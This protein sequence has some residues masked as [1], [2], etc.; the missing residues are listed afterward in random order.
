LTISHSRAERGKGQLY[1]G[2]AEVVWNDINP[3]SGLES[4]GYCHYRYYCIVLCGEEGTQ[5]GADDA[6]S[7][8]S[9]DS[10][11]LPPAPNNNGGM[12]IEDG[13]TNA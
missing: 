5:T 1:C 12:A 7:A 6:G 2:M 8:K 3:S 10:A 4:A 13:K 11:A 9:V